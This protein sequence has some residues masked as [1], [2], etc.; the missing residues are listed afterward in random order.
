M[1]FVEIEFVDNRP[2]WFPFLMAYPGGLSLPRKSGDTTV[3]VTENEKKR[4]MKCRNGLKPVFAEK[5]TSR[6][7]KT[8]EA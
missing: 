4:L 2:L 7:S 1:K 3:K 5:P 8:E 6:R